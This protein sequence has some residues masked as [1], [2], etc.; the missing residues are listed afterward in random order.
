MKTL[1]VGGLR[2]RTAGPVAGPSV[3]LCHGYGAPGDDLCGL[4]SA[5]EAGPGVR[6]FF[7][8]APLDLGGGARAWWPIDMVAI[9]IAL[10]QGRPRVFDTEATPAGMTDALARTQSCLQALV[11]DHGVDP[12][13]T[14]LG[15]FSQGAMVTTDLFFNAPERWAGLMILSGTLLAGGRWRPALAQNAR[16][17]R[18]FQSHGRQD[19]IL[20]FAVAEELHTLLAGHGAAVEWV[21]FHG[22]HTISQGVCARAGAWLQSVLR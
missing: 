19:P 3:I 2:V 11:R 10:M 14:V 4:S 16:D 18:V 5:I 17:R 8:E 7:P 13:N 21:P 6:W 12:A 22:P 20:P 9:Q 15:G 1:E